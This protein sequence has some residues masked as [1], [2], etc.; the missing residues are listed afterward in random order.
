MRKAVRIEKNQLLVDLLSL[1]I[2]VAIVI[3]SADD[4]NYFNAVKLIAI[5]FCNFIYDNRVY[6]FSSTAERDLKATCYF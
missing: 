4:R 2:S 5:P 6:R 1:A 3:M